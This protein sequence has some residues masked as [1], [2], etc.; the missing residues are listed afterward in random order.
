MQDILWKKIIEQLFPDFVVFFL[1]ELAQRVD[2]SKPYQF[3]D[4]EFETLAINTYGKQGRKHVD[5]LVKVF[6]K[7]GHEQWVLIH[8]EI[9]G[10]HDKLFQQRM[11]TYFYR[12]FD[13]YQQ[14]I[15]AIAIFTDDRTDWSPDRFEYKFA[16]TELLYRYPVYK[17]L[18][19][20]ENGL[21]A[22]DNP[23]AQV[24]LATLYALQTKRKGDPFKF[25]FKLELTQLLFKKGFP[26]AK[27][28]A[29]FDFLDC[30][31]SLDDPLL[32]EQ[33]FEEAKHMATTQ[34]QIEMIGDFQKVAM[35]RGE[36]MGLEKG[37]EKGLQQGLEKGLQ[38]AQV[39]I[40]R[41][42]LAENMDE[43]L[44]AKLTGLSISAIQGL[45]NAP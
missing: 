9:Q 23:F 13:R 2:F 31:L 15:A 35:R 3:L 8:T 11:F 34:E 45:K 21:I 41:K 19:Q 42:M 36:A 22:S 43:Q 14:K 18:D 32:Q 17:I 7:E 27:I 39:S 20:N 29:V 33:F 37:L 38:E 1:P 24:V 6:L 40:A 28:K 10:Y 44:I 16:E 5:K 12:I 30:L 4:K 25:Q 26:S